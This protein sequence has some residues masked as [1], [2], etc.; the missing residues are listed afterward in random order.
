VAEVHP[1]TTSATTITERN[2]NTVID[3]LTM[4]AKLIEPPVSTSVEV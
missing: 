1:P 4:A 2:L 3:C